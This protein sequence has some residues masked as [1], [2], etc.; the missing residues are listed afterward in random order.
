MNQIGT[1]THLFQ[2]YH[3]I[4]NQSLR[5]SNPLNVN[6]SEDIKYPDFMNVSYTNCVETT[7]IQ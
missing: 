3:S 4:S 1:V 6:V 2:V 5:T 7:A